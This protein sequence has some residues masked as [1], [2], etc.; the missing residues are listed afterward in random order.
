MRAR[1]GVIGVAA[2]AIAALVGG[3]GAHAETRPPLRVLFVGNSLTATNDLPAVVA[4]L[5]RATGR[6]LGYRTIAFG[7]FALED[8]WAQGDARAALAS[9]TWDV[10]VMQQGPSALPES[11]VNLREWT[12]R[13]ADEA[14]A[15]GTRPALLTVWPESYR[16]GA[17]RDVIASYRR[18]AAAARADLFPAGLAW[19]IAWGCRPAL[20]L[21]GPDGFHPSALGTYAAALVL[22]G[23]LFKAP[24]VGIRALMPARVGA[25][26]AVLL[27]KAAASSLGRRTRPPCRNG[28]TAP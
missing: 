19:Q 1:L 17:L 5:A 20:G 2:I 15:A 16:R 4:G 3:H 22:Y 23:R 21:Y 6:S 12:S 11:Q 25:R 18:A 8:H 24:L 13:F 28:R 14:R 9:R 10:I 27:Q 26:T 7:G